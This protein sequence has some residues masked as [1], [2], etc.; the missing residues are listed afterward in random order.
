MSH[1]SV[2]WSVRIQQMNVNSRV[3]VSVQCVGCALAGGLTDILVLQ[4]GLVSLS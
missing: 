1:A 2:R 3:F 4:L